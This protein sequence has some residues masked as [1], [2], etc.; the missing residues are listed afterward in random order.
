[1]K[2]SENIE[3]KSEIE[4]FLCEIEDFYNYCCT[5]LENSTTDHISDLTTALI[6]AKCL[7]DE[8]SAEQSKVSSII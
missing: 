7:L 6:H 5:E 8:I 3:Y 2:L 1:L 4:E